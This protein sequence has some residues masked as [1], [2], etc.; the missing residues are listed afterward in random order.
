M[1]L[2]AAV[3]GVLFSTAIPGFA[4]DREVWIAAMERIAGPVVE[5]LASGSLD[6]KM[7]HRSGAATDFASRLEAVGRTFCGILPWF[8]LPDDETAEGRLRAKWR[9]LVKK[10]LANAVAPDSPSRLVFSDKRRQPL[11]D[12]AFLA[13]G[14]LRAPRFW[15]GFDADVKANVI[16]RMK[17]TRNMEPYGN[18]WLLFAG[19]IEAFLLDRMG[20]CDEVRLMRGVK[21]FL[22]EGGWYVGDG[23]YS[24]GSKFALD[25]YNSF[26]IQPMLWDIVAAMDR[27]GRKE[28]K[29]L[30]DEMKPRFRR[31]ADVQE[32]LISPEGAYPL[33]GRSVCYRFGLFQH[34]AMS[35][36]LGN[37]FHSASNGAIRSALTAVIRRQCVDANFDSE[38]WL[39][40]GF[41]GTQPSAAESYVS[42]GSPYL[43]CTVFLPLGLPPS[44]PFWS[45]PAEDWTQKAAWSGQPVRID[46]RLPERKAKKRLAPTGGGGRQVL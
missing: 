5:N 17:E 26:V 12:A 44:H 31:Y 41:N 11:V 7:P 15:S 33:V 45:D 1:K 25:G 43:A 18:N 13:H 23:F 42:R 35:V 24:D 4:S 22:G 16:E 10:G 3:V 38:G 14:L 29:A 8:E 39:T 37:D 27:A 28:A 9:V 2:T 30:L 19:I 21:A 40:V 6:A 46:H 34:L 36:M 32:R 20:A